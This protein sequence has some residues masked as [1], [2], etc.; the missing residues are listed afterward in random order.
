MKRNNHNLLYS[1]IKP[2]TN[3]LNLI[4]MRFGQKKKLMIYQLVKEIKE[5]LQI[6]KQC[7]DKKLEP[8]MY[9]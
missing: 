6:F 4:K 3:H 5:R 7:I 9:S 2:Q 8:K 1:R